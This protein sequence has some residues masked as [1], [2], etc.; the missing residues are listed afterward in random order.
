M[1]YSGAFGRNPNGEKTS[2]SDVEKSIKKNHKFFNSYAK[3]TRRRFDV[4]T[5]LLQ[6]YETTSSA[7]YI[8]YSYK[9]YVCIKT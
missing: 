1:N 2:S 8:L 3:S 9:L 5:T 4:A 6:R 7:G